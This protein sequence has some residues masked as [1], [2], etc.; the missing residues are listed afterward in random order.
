MPR[1]P[2]ARWRPSRWALSGT[3][4]AIQASQGSDL[5]TTWPTP[6]TTAG[7]DMPLL[8]DA[9]G[10]AILLGL[11]RS[12]SFGDSAWQPILPAGCPVMVRLPTLLVG[13]GSAI[14]QH[15]AAVTGKLPGREGAAMLTMAR[16]PAA[17]AARRHGATGVGTR[18]SWRGCGGGLRELSGCRR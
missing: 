17:I 6:T 5:R 14:R 2:R 3:L 15:T 7:T 8:T 4:G 13:T 10:T 18:G 9:N 1:I 12:R 11:K 16:D